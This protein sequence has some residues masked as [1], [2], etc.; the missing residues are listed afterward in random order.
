M[1]ISADEVPRMPPPD[2]HQLAA[3]A[4]FTQ[5]LAE[6]GL[7]LIEPAADMGFGVMARRHM[8]DIGEC[9]F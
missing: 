6:Q 2:S 9:Q 4:S 5:L 8:G 7:D 1:Q 3:S